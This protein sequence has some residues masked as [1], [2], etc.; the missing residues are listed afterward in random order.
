M[1]DF[2]VDLLFYFTH[3]HTHIHENESSGFAH[4]FHKNLF[5]KQDKVFFSMFIAQQKVPLEV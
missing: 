5:Y 2:K 1:V 4:V 3:T